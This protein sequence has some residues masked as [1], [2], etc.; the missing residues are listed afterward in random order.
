MSTDVMSYDEI[1]YTALMAIAYYATSGSKILI[2]FIP[3]C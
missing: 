2:V 3:L 1:R